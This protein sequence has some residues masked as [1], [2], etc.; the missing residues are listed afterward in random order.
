[1]LQY[2]EQ[3]ALV[4]PVWQYGALSISAS[5]DERGGSEWLH[6]CFSKPDRVPTHD[7]LMLV[8]R[9]FF[10]RES[11]VVQVFP[12]ADEYVNDFPYALHLWERLGEQRLVPDLRTAHAGRL[13]L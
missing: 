8:R 4:H 2:V 3:M 12:P 11:V 9:T 13:S 7:D 1:M 5:I 6:V 10:R